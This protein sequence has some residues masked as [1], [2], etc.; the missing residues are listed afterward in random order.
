[1]RDSQR[2]R[3]CGRLT[4]RAPTG[5]W[6]GQGRLSL[7]TCLNFKG[8]CRG[9]CRFSGRG[10]VFCGGTATTHGL[11]TG[12]RATPTF[13]RGTTSYSFGASLTTFRTRV[14]KIGCYKGLNFSCRR[15]TCCGR[16]ECSTIFG[17][18]GDRSRSR[19]GSGRSRSAF[20]RTGRQR[21]SRARGS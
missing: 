19:A 11:T 6:E 16:A 10:R 2:Q 5:G 18:R 4:R 7:G 9:I 15:V 13:C 3:R 17:T 1:M 20:S 8:G 21:G 12:V 14:R